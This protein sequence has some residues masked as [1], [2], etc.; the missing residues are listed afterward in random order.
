VAAPEP[1]ATAWG[2][3][4]A[5][6]AALLGDCAGRRVGVGPD[7]AGLARASLPP[8]ALQSDLAPAL[9]DGVLDA[10]LLHPTQDSLADELAEAARALRPGGLA[11]VVAEN[12]ESLGRRLAAALGR[13]AGPPGLAAAAIR[14]ALHAA[15][16]VPL[17]LDGHSLDAW[18]ATADT[19]PPGLAPHEPAAALLE[20]AGGAAGP[21][22]AAWIL[23]LA[24]KP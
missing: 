14:G 12:A 20:E 4:P 9:P 19:P 7:A 16:L 13:P 1:Q 6:V 2:A 11:L 21:R 18:R 10:A 5:R 15:G 23:L 17:R 8:S 24:R 3:L 22:H